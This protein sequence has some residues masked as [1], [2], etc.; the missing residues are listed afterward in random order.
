MCAYVYAYGMLVT[1][2]LVSVYDL[3]VTVRALLARSADEVSTR[4]VFQGCPF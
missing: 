4:Y 1:V 2:R 3:I